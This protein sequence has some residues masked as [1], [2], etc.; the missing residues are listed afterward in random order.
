VQAVPLPSPRCEVAV[1]EAAPGT[2]DLAF[3]DGLQKMHSHMVGF[4]P[5]KQ[6]EKYVA[7]GH[8]LIAEG[9]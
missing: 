1:R 2:D 3:I 8:V 5:R 6:L 4:M 7:D 9:G